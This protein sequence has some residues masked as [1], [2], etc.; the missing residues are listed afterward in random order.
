VTSDARRGMN[1]S[2]FRAVNERLEERA[3]DRGPARTFLIV[4]ECA[5]EE[6]TARITIPIAEYET[7]RSDPTRFVVLDGH[8]DPSCERVVSTHQGYN[9]V[10]KFGEAGLVAEIENPRDG[11]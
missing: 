7:V 2:W 4:C 10:A 3:V 11:Q 5:Q 6:C 8:D 1:E 9:V